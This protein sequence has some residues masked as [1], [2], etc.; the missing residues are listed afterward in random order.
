[1]TAYIEAFF[2]LLSL[3]GWLIVAISVVM[4]GLFAFGL[5]FELYATGMAH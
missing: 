2:V 4:L 1:M 3:G 5:V